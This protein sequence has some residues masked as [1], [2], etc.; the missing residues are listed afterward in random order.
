MIDKFDQKE[1]LNQSFEIDSVKS[2]S[3]EEDKDKEEIPDLIEE[4]LAIGCNFIADTN[5][6]TN[7]MLITKIG[8][9]ELKEEKKVEDGKSAVKVSELNHTDKLNIEYVQKLDTATYGP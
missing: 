1:G 7:Q 9:L 8:E 6:D 5:P 3:E 2:N 4:A